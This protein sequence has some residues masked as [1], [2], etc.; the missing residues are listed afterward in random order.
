MHSRSFTPRS[1]AIYDKA[2]EVGTGTPLDT[3]VC[4]SRDLLLS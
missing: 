4:E 2:N 1:L 3:L